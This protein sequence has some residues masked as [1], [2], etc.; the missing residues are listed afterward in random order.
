MP[1]LL[2]LKLCFFKLMIKLFS[3]H[4]SHPFCIFPIIGQF[5][6]NFD[7]FHIYHDMKQ[8]SLNKLRSLKV[9]RN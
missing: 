2:E 6:A 8:T 4:D 7:N 1:L 9:F 3:Q 5:Q